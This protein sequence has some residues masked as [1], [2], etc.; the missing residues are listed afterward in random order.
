LVGTFSGV[1]PNTG[2]VLSFVFATGFGDVDNS[3]FQIAGN[4][5]RTSAAFDFERRPV[6]S[7]RVR[8]ADQLNA[9]FERVFTIAVTNVNDAPVLD[10]SGSPFVVL[11]VGGRQSDEMRQ[12]V[13][14][15]DM[16]GR[17]RPIVDQDPG[18]TSGI[19]VTGTDEVFGRFQYFVPSSFDAQPQE[20]DWVNF[21]E[22]SDTNA[23]LLPSLA[24]IRI[25]S[26][27][28]PHHA[29]GAPFLA[30]GS[31]LDAGLVYRAWDG[32]SG[33]AG[34]RA[35]ASVNGGATAF[36]SAFETATVYFEARMFRVFNTNAQLNIYTLEAEFNALIANPALVD[37]STSAFTGFTVL[38]SPVP[39]LGTVPLFRLYYGVQFNADGTETDMGYRYLTSNAGE[40]SF[41]EGLG[42]VSKR[43]LRDGAYFRELGVNNGTAILGYIYSTEQSGTFP[44]TQVYRT[45][46]FDKPTRPGGTR[47]GSPASSN[48]KQENGDHVYTTN[49][50]F[51]TSLPGTWRIESGR[52]FVRALAQD[53]T[54]TST[55]PEMAKVVQPTR[56]AQ[57]D[58]SFAPIGL[59]VGEFPQSG[60]ATL[61]EQ[62]LAGLMS[63]DI[64]RAETAPVVVPPLE[65]ENE[66][67]SGWMV[68]SETVSVEGLDLQFSGGIVEDL[69]ME[70]TV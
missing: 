61:D 48:R 63:I 8:A 9:G 13:F 12:G 69:L 44:L 56:A 42:P 49:T 66:S 32:T 23:L 24:K 30:L 6:L 41:L 33:T 22:V 1:D 46:Q 29:S 52:G 43:G 5:L 39:E 11:G 14:V 55:V 64:G 27:L 60:L 35:N 36:S 17:G 45:D 40:A 54:A 10:N 20:G 25:V 37:R 38:L 57:G 58:F 31:K 62:A 50:G 70:A 47:E 18:A 53:P 21:G 4:E 34:G 26:T 16:L 65:G 19:T 3:L 28:L 7:I 68:D 15:L 67:G 2:D 59:A 51:E